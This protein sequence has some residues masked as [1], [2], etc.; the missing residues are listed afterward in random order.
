MNKNICCRYDKLYFTNVSALT[1]KYGTCRAKPGGT[2]AVRIGLFFSARYVTLLRSLRLLLTRPPSRQNLLSSLIRALHIHFLVFYMIC[3]NHMY[4]ICC[5]L[6]TLV[7]YYVWCLPS[8]CVWYLCG[9]LFY[10][11]HLHLD[12]LIAAFLCAFPRT[13]LNY[14]YLLNVIGSECT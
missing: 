5:L 14:G 2:C 4:D 13:A 12:L 10:F 1:V 9:G 3:Y 6:S 8:Y 7:F 11:A